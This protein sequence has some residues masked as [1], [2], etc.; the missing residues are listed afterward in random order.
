MYLDKLTKSLTGH[1]PSTSELIA[2]ATDLRI[3]R[4]TFVDD[5]WG[6]TDNLIKRVDAIYR[7]I[8]KRPADS[9]GSTT[10]VNK[11]RSG[12][13][14]N[15]VYVALLTST[16]YTNANSSNSAYVDS[17]YKTLLGRTADT[18]GKN[19]W[20]TALNGGQSRASV[21]LTF[22]TSDER[23]LKVID[24]LYQSL[25]GHAADATNRATY[26]NR[27]RSGAATEDVNQWILA[28]DEYYAKLL[29]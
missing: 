22:L 7:E 11:L 17:L 12:G 28:S 8:L 20:V 3:N 13:T 21:A 24:S 14:E 10:F 6:L 23:R 2:L 27:L 9:T 26:L 19:S 18:A 1:A 15:D 25:L 16:E 29:K 5:A 4:G